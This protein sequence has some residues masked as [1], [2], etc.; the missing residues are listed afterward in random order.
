MALTIIKKGQINLDAPLLDKTLVNDALVKAVSK[1]APAAF[2]QYYTDWSNWWNELM[3]Q[4]NLWRH[5]TEVIVFTPAEFMEA[6]IRVKDHLNGS[7]GCFVQESPQW[8]HYELEIFGITCLRVADWKQMLIV[9]HHNTTITLP[10]ANGG[11]FYVLIHGKVRVFTFQPGMKQIKFTT[12]K[13]S[14]H[15]PFTKFDLHSP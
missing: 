2:K 9:D 8:P 5:D 3:R 14:I 7:M 1:A 15:K 12:H 13:P 11:S 10:H 4:L 6:C